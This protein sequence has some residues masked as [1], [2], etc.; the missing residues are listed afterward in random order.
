VCWKLS[1]ISYDE[2]IA[3]FPFSVILISDED[4]KKENLGMLA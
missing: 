2:L 3:Y 1:I 4:R